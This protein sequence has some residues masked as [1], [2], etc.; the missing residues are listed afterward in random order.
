MKPTWIIGIVA[1][2]ALLV[3]G[4]AV[5]LGYLEIP[6][7]NIGLQPGDENAP[8]NAVYCD[9]TDMQILDMI[10]TI[11][12]KDL[13]NGVGITFV[14]GLNMQA[15]GSDDVISTEVITYYQNLY[16]DWYLTLDNRTGG[17]GWSARN[18]LWTNS[19]TGAT[20]AR[21][22]MVGTGVTVKQAYGYDAIT[23]T[24]DGPV[25]TYNALMLWIATS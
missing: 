3:V 23:I 20:L 5:A 21:S 13:D 2:L 16:E 15:C 4:A 10:E 18:V 1:V 6:G 22:V 19:P 14:R 11:A 8:P 12:G 9:Y 24:A 7:L 17:A 25:I